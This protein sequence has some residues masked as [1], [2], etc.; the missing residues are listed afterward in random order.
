MLPG[1]MP[2]SERLLHGPLRGGAASSSPSGREHLPIP[3]VRESS[4]L[5]DDMDPVPPQSP[6]EGEL[7][8][9]RG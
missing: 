7:R 5:G 2:A 1:L 8:Q 9:R 6:G 4:F 3:K